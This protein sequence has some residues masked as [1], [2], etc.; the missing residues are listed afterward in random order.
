MILGGGA[1]LS[2]LCNAI[3]Q[4]IKPIIEKDSNSIVN[5]IIPSNPEDIVVIGACKFND[6]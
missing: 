4:K 5:V 3:V 1:R 2:G 6:K